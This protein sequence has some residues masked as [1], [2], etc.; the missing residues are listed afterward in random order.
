M[1][2]VIAPSL[3]TIDS[4]C[5]A[6]VRTSPCAGA[7]GLAALFP[8]HGKQTGTP[9][10]IARPCS[11][12]DFRLTKNTSSVPAGF[13]DVTWAPCRYISAETSGDVIRTFG[14]P[15]KPSTTCPRSAKRVLFTILIPAW[16]SH[17]CCSMLSNEDIK[18]F[19]LIASALRED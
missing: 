3:A 17:N 13:Q 4:S 10:R 1:L 9:P 11:H 19:V 5:Q 18:E 15:P 8:N 14:N 6:F 7:V 16:N 12:R 2:T